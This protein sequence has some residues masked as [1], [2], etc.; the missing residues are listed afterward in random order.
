MNP[1]SVHKLFL[2]DAWA[3]EKVW[4]CIDQLTDEQF[5][6]PVDY[7]RGSIRNQ[8]VHMT[9]V[10]QRWVLR[11][12]RALMPERL[13]FEDFPNKAIT[14]G[15][16]DEIQ[17]QTMDYVASL[18]QA[19]LDEAVQWEL[20]DRGIISATPRWEILLHMAN[21]GTDHRAQ[22]LSLLNQHFGIQT[23]EQDMILYFIESH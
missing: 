22:V 11:M 17:R 8:V 20:P 14:K 6:Q 9:S 21:H 3:F 10:S 16:W 5:V 1:E 23:V 13:A 12:Q 7:S 15:K 19:Q 4:N 2:Y 18:N